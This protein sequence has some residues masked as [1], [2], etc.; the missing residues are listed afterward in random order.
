MPIVE[1][2]LN[3]FRPLGL[4]VVLAALLAGAF[5]VAAQ[6]LLVEKALPSDAVLVVVLKDGGALQEQWRTTA[7]YEVL[8]DPEMQEML[9]PLTDSLGGLYAQGKAMS[10]V[11]FE[12]LKELL[13]G[14]AGIAISMTGGRIPIIQFIARPADIEK[15]RDAAMQAMTALATLARLEPPAM[16]GDTARMTKPDGP[17]IALTVR[18]GVLLFTIRGAA[19]PGAEAH[20]QALGR[21]AG[22]VGGLADDAE[23]NLL[24]ARIDDDF[25]AWAYIGLLPWFQKNMGQANPAGPVLGMM[26]MNGMQGIIAGIR[27][28][29][30]G[31]RTR[32][33]ARID[34]AL[35]G[36]QKPASPL[37]PEDLA[38]IPADSLA[39]GIG[40]LDLVALYD[41]VMTVLGMMGGDMRHVRE[42]VTAMETELGL[43][44][45]NDVLALFGNRVMSFVGD[46]ESPAQGQAVFLSIADRQDAQE[47]LKRV[48][49]AIV[50]A[51][52]RKAGPNTDAFV[53]INSIDR[54]EFQQIYPQ[55]VIPGALAPNFT[56]TDGWVGFGLSAR[57]TLPATRY[58]LHHDRD[59]TQRED[60]ARV[61]RTMPAPYDNIH[62]TDVGACFG[63]LVSLVQLLTDIGATALKAGIVQGEVPL[64]VQADAIWGMDPGRF[65]DSAMLREKLFGSVSVVCRQ[66]DGLLFENFSPV[67]PIPVPSQD[68]TAIGANGLATVSIMAGMLL[69][70]LSRARAEARRANA[71]GMG[72]EGQPEG[73][74]GQYRFALTVNN[75]RGSGEYRNRERV[76][77]QGDF[78]PD[79]Q[80]FDEWTGEVK[81]VDDVGRQDTTLTMPFAATTIA[82]TFK[83]APPEASGAFLEMN[84]RVVMEAE[85]ATEIVPGR[86]AMDKV[87]WTEAPGYEG[88]IGSVMQAMPNLDLNA[89]DGNADGP[90]LN[91]KIYFQNPGVY[92][93]YARLPVL[94]GLDNSI[95]LGFDDSLAYSSYYNTMNDWSWLGRLPNDQKAQVV[96]VEPGTHTVNIWMREDG[97][98]VDRVMLDN[99]KILPISKDPAWPPESRRLP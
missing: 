7:L 5:P 95:N 44:L 90:A 75:G 64:P 87:E 23:Y 49:E 48:L 46:P 73:G 62:Y 56:V 78:P 69:P 3:S 93:I 92:S 10:P 97:V 30:R 66:P 8:Q 52:R 40:H 16:A 47:K 70:A 19:G 36:P 67:G 9:K 17:D 81:S 2:R 84:G 77:I 71:R 79:G 85:H 34:P 13:T 57:A 68:V 43:N 22:A 82:A 1:R 41:R 98:V 32:A 12:P 11:P 60:F 18:D 83:D 88:A 29:D 24:R 89:G 74:A 37:G 4:A 53:K 35:A 94:A 55:S 38:M 80:V 20:D 14:E 86:G 61:L 45:R 15:A 42:G 51:I 65:P 33:F 25:A 6:P 96:V 91:F 31:F 63:N 59:I 21:L 28:E 50:A 72:E 99:N 26:G 54:G 39:F 27:I 76:T 58:M